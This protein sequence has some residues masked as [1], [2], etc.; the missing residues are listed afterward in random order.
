MIIIHCVAFPVP[1]VNISELN[2]VIQELYKEYGDEQKR[3]LFSVP[4]EQLNRTDDNPGQ[5]H[6]EEDVM[7]AISVFRYHETVIQGIAKNGHKNAHQVQAQQITLPVFP[8][9]LEQGGQICI[10]FRSA[11]SASTF[12]KTMIPLIRSVNPQTRSMGSTAPI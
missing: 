2:C 5:K 9:K 12:G 6:G 8:G 11:N 4:E 10:F 1:D 3:S 7:I